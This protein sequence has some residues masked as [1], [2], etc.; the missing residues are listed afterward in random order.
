MSELKDTLARIPAFAN[1]NE[2]QKKA[3]AK[4]MQLEDYPDGHTFTT[5][6]EPGD[7]CHVLV[8]GEVAILRTD[9]VTGEQEELKV[10]HA[11]EIFGML[12][13]LEK[14]PAAA[15]CVARGPARVAS[16]PR[17]D[18]LLLFKVDAPIAFHFQWLVA[19]QLARDLLNRNNTLR[20]QLLSE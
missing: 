11:G 6:G 9:E 10:L 17:E 15:T 20:A 2:A 4:L 3:L 13:L 5:Q 8:S 16:L 12:S 19:E 7:A 1:F 14:L 18:Y